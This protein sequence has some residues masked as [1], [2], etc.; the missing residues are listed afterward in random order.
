MVVVHPILICWVARQAQVL[1]NFNRQN[2]AKEDES[3]MELSYRKMVRN[4][5][6]IISCHNRMS[7]KW[8]RF[9]PHMVTFSST[10]DSPGPVMPCIATRSEVCSHLHSIASTAS[11]EIL[12]VLRERGV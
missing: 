8:P 2:L 7:Q 3:W 9:H 12:R 1:W 5:V 6:Y 10:Q 11:A 4:E